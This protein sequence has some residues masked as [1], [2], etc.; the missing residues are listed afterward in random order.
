MRKTV[1][2]LTAILLTSI[3]FC[4]CSNNGNTSEPSKDISVV[5]QPSVDESKSSS[6]NSESSTESSL[7]KDTYAEIQEQV[8]LPEMVDLNSTKK[9]DRYY[10]IQEEDVADYAGGINNSG[11]QQD[12]IVL[13]KATSEEAAERIVAALQTRY[14]AK[15][16][17]NENY[18]AEQA[19]MIKAC[20]VEKDGLYVSMIISPDAEKIT[21]IYKEAIQ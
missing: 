6:E 13:I 8:T 10:G 3:A 5:S 9:L 21:K 4:A 7:L 16:S 1:I 17:E 18:N 11:V 14:D 15:Y 12:E 2:L 19:A 20:K